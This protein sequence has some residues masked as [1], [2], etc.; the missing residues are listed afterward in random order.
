MP[1]VK[2]V[3]VYLCSHA[4]IEY[5]DVDGLESPV[6]NF[7]EAPCSDLECG[8]TDERWFM[9]GE[10]A[11]FEEQ[12]LVKHLW[13]QLGNLHSQLSNIIQVFDATNPEAI[14][15][16]AITILKGPNA[17]IIDFL[18]AHDRF[19]QID[20]WLFEPRDLLKYALQFQRRGP[21][22]PFFE[23]C[24]KQAT[25]RID[26]A[27]KD[28]AE[29]KTAVRGLIPDRVTA[30]GREV[31]VRPTRARAEPRVQWKGVK[32]SD[33]IE[34]LVL[35]VRRMAIAKTKACPMHSLAR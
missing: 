6:H 9:E 30:L 5:V 31:S 16:L 3:S 29:L 20:K 26:D 11:S 19:A 10:A 35:G 21:S 24:L 25:L 1:S 15:Q 34:S 14:A 2:V 13:C 8:A 23:Y 12:D 17:D 18:L 28:V 7:H 27:K 33:Q 32:R 22:R 4:E